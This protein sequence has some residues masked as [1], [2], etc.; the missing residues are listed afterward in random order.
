MLVGRLKASVGPNGQ[1]TALSVGGTH[2]I[3]LVVADVLVVVVIV[4]V[5]VVVVVLVHGDCGSDG[6]SQH[7]AQDCG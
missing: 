5:V 2:A 1:P 6:N 4:L 3:V 7:V